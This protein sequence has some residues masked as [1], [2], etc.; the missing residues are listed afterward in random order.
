[1][2]SG[3]SALKGS[4]CMNILPKEFKCYPSVFTVEDEYQI[5]VPAKKELL[6]W[7]RVGNEEYYD[8]TNGILRSSSPIHKI[9]VP[10]AE[11]DKAGE[12][13]VCFNQVIKRLPYFTRTMPKKEYTFTFKSVN[14]GNSIRAFHISDSHGK[15]NDAVKAGLNAGEIDFLIFNGDIASHSGNIKNIEMVYQIASGITK[16]EIPCVFSR[17]NHDTRGKFAE[18]LADYT[19]N[20]NGK[21]YY[22]FSIGDLWGLLVDCGEDKLDTD[23]EYGNT[24]CC[25]NFRLRETKFIENVISEKAYDDGYKYKMVVCHVPVTFHFTDREKFDI[26]NEIYESWAKNISENVCPDLYLYGHTHEIAT[27]LPGEHKWER[28]QNCPAIM[29]GKPKTL[30]DKD[31]Y[32]GTLIIFKDGKI[33]AEAVDSENNRVKL[34]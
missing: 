14:K 5:I 31:G 26:E 20:S 8:D 29:G 13:T 33:T 18:F 1:M 21:S 3:V 24:V 34:L 19:P 22:T 28:N 4:V 15:V 11:L 25:H 32:T 30:N 2:L 17:G 16:G 7:V 9:I 12:Y 27:I 23:I 10:K 6:M